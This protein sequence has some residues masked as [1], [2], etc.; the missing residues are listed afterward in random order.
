M[1]LRRR[2]ADE[3]SRPLWIDHESPLL[4]ADSKRKKQHRPEKQNVSC[5][6][7]PAKHYKN[8][9]LTSPNKPDYFSV[10]EFIRKLLFSFL[11]FTLHEVELANSNHHLALISYFKQP[12]P[13]VQ[14]MKQA[15]KVEE[16]EDNG[17]IS[18][19]E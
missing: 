4:T 10:V 1:R 11:F 3:R 9:N 16:M 18:F 13:A 7:S 17:V 14:E 15:S 5:F 6:Q 8:K 12:P 19:Q 2:N